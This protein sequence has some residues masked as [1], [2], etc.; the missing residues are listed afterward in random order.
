ME[1][2]IEPKI[3]WLLDQWQTLVNTFGD[4]PLLWIVIILLLLV[5]SSLLTFVRNLASMIVSGFITVFIIGSIILF[6]TS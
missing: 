2:F 1:N 5:A 6:I 3:Q 4:G